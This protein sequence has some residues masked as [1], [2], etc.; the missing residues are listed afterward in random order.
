MTGRQAGLR[1]HEANFPWRAVEAPS[2]HRCGVG[3]LIH[4]RR[5]VFG[6][7]RKTRVNQPFDSARHRY[8]VLL[9][10]PTPA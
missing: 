2:K 1:T 10:H 5:H 7:P 8:S 3:D 6:I 9:T 4:D